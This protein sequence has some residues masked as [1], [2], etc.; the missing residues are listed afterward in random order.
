MVHSIKLTYFNI[1]AAAEPTRLALALAGQKY[2]DDRIE[3]KDWPTLKPKTP[4]GALPLMVIDNG[5]VKTQSMAML[6]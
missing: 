1:E 2:E 4:Y 3:F 6:R 5:P